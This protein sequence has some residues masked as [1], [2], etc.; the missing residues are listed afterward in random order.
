MK[1]NLSLCQ[2]QQNAGLTRLA[3]QSLMVTRIFKI[4]EEKILKSIKPGYK[5]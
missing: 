2:S 3:K 5:S 1:A 4:K